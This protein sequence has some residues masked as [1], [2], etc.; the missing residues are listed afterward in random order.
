[1]ICKASFLAPCGLISPCSFL[2]PVTS[3]EYML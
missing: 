1:M 2:P 3:K